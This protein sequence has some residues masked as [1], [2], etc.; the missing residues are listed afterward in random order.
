MP[1]QPHVNPLAQPAAPVI[2]VLVA[3]AEADMRTYVARCLHFGAPATMQVLE[4]ATGAAALAHASTADLIVLDLN[5]RDADDTPFAQALSTEPA[6]RHTPTL[7]LTNRDPGRFSVPTLPRLAVLT[8]PFN[9]RT[10]R[11]KVRDLLQAC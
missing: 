9:A 6:L 1:T 2:T 8:K 5:L 7:V 10:L 11:S 4:A 3:D